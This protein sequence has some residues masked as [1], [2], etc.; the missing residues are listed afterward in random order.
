MS[1][2]ERGHGHGHSDAPGEH[3]AYAPESVGCAVF[4][5]SDSRTPENDTSGDLICE[6]LLAARHRALARAIVQ[7]D[8]AAIREAVSAALERDDVEAVI[9]TGG[10]G[11]SPRDVTPEAIEPLL[12]KVLAGF[13]ELFRVLSYEEI[14][15]A[16]QL[17]RALAGTAGGSVVSSIAAP[18]RLSELLR[19]ARGEPP[20]VELAPHPAPG[21]KCPLLSLG[22]GVEHP[23][24]CRCQGSGGLRLHKQPCSVVD[25]D[26]GNAANVGAD[27][28]T[29]GG[30]SLGEYEPERFGVARRHDNR[31]PNEHATAA[32]ELRKLRRRLITRE[33]DAVC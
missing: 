19:V 31:R 2:S 3:R 23:V 24:D 7:D 25:H 4:T 18:R 17:S 11:I 29:A 20:Q 13:G 8:V 32:V 12:D 26:I 6:R 16:A 30:H 33:T 10:T 22:G 1:H 14:G 27:D 15:A 9:V 21:E 5:V 28:R